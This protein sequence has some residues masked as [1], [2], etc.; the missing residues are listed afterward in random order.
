MPVT[1][2]ATVP[3]DPSA[4]IGEPLPYRIKATTVLDGDNF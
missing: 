1:F 2:R 3:S 4:V